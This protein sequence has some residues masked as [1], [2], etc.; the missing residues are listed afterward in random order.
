ML[1]FVLLGAGYI[2]PRHAQAIK[3]VGGELIGFLDPNDSVGWIDSYFPEA[4]YFSEFERFDRFCHKSFMAGNDI[5][6]AVICTPN[7]LQ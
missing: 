4:R 5:D 3:D 7:Y 1:R 6:Y 2:A